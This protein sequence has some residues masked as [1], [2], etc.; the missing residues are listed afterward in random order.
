MK[1]GHCSACGAEAIQAPS[2]NWYHVGRLSCPQRSMLA[3]QPV[4]V[5][6][7]GTMRQARDDEQP[8]RFVEEVIDVPS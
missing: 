6:P 7:D 5:D 8:A 2:G 4:I 1:R 3:W